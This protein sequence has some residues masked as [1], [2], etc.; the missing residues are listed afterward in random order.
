M[1]RREDGMGKVG[2]TF[3][4]GL[5]VVIVYVGYKMIPIKIRDAEFYDFMVEQARW[6]GRERP[7]VIQKTILDRAVQLELP[8]ERKNLDVQKVGRDH[9]RIQCVY[10]VDVDF[11]FY[12]HE[13]TFQH[14]IDEANMNF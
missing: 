11:P 14:Y 6:A 8:I 10:T 1:R 4:V 12:T 5:L 3:W 2:V 7:E 9:T 13:W